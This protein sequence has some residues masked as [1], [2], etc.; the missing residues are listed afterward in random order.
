MARKCPVDYDKYLLFHRQVFLCG[1]AS[2]SIG[3]QARK[4][5]NERNKLKKVFE[6][7]ALIVI[8]DS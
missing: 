6:L 2:S 3:V 1:V 5:D 8:L 4:H 7:Y